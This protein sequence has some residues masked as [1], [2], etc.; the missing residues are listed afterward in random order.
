MVAPV[1]PFPM[2][3]LNG[4]WALYDPDTDI[5]FVAKSGES[6]ADL[7][8]RYYE[9]AEDKKA[10][11]E[12]RYAIL[13]QKKNQNSRKLLAIKACVA[14]VGVSIVVFGYLAYKVLG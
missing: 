7:W 11:R 6:M 2:K 8:L 9:M 5:T 4:K 12:E 13:Y 14:M 1:Q 10:Q 3:L